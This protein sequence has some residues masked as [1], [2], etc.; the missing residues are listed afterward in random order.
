VCFAS[1]NAHMHTHT[2]PVPLSPSL[3]PRLPVAG[4]AGQVIT[5]NHESYLISADSAESA[6]SWVAAIRR[7][8]H[9]VMYQH[10]HTTAHSARRVFNHIF[11]S[12]TVVVC[13]GGAW[14]RR[15][16]LRLGWEEASSLFSF[17][18]VSNSSEITVSNRAMD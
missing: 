17:T 7:V 10:T 15:S 3:V 8:M 11:H 4:S 18:G 1:S 2:T 6:D 13:L 14:R 5:G 16:R 12:R 9:E